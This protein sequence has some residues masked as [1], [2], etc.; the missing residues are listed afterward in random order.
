MEERELIEKIKW[1]IIHTESRSEIEAYYI[2]SLIKLAELKLKESYKSILDVACGNGRLHKFLRNYGFEVYGIDINEYLISLAKRENEGFEDYYF[3]ADMRDFDL[4]RKFDVCISWFSS[5]GY[6]DDKDNLKVLRNISNHLRTNGI[7]ILEAL[8][9]ENLPRAFERGN[10]I[11]RVI[12]ISDRLIEISEREFFPNDGIVKFNNV[13]YRK[14]GNDLKF[15]D[16]LEVSLKVYSI[17]ELENMAREANM[18][19]LFVFESLTF[20]KPS[21]RTDRITAVFR[22]I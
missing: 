3:I 7:F 6:F 4:K 19:L 11:I 1:H 22:R 18:E 13:I 2:Y 10:K 8:Y 15:V 16:K 21:S 17:D 5:F 20:E 9:R 12:E 14:E